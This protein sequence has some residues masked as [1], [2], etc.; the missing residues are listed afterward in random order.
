VVSVLVHTHQNQE[1][2]RRALR[3]LRAQ[4]DITWEAVV[5]DSGDGEGLAVARGFSD[6]RIRAYRNPGQG[7]VAAL[8]AA[9]EVVRGAVIALLNDSDWW[10]DR[11][12]LHRICQTLRGGEALLH[13]RAVETPELE[14][15]LTAEALRWHNPIP[16]SGMAYPTVMHDWL[17]GFDPN[18]GQLWDWDW[19]LRVT[20]SGVPLRPIP[21]TCVS[22][23][24]ASTQHAAA[25]A[26]DLAQL[27]QKHG[28]GELRQPPSTISLESM[29]ADD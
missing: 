13:S 21:D 12:Y 10:E 23:T 24:P 17:G 5:M 27:C 11:L 3:Y 4:T 28:L 6:H 8:N 20:A 16:V 9:L 19:N 7:Q 18:M 29:A 14:V 26:R 15:E 22:V 1:G 2:L 25:H